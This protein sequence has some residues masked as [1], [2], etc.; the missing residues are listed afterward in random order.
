MILKP[1]IAT[2]AFGLATT[3][4]VNAATVDVSTS[5]VPTPGLTGFDTWTV[6]L[7]ASEGVLIG[8]DATFTGEQINQINPFTL[9]TVFSDSNAAITGSGADPAQDTQFLFNTGDLTIAP[10][11]SEESGELL[12]SA[13]ALTGGPDSSLAA[14]SID[15]AQIVLPTG[16]SAQFVGE[17]VVFDTDA[18]EQLPAV[19]VTATIPEPTSL[20]LLSLGGFTL[21][22]RRRARG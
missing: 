14:S 9:A 22:A 3:V 10:G 5:S 1:L 11:T 6:T 4:S 2:A 7:T 19:D 16:G 12:T 8:F 20:A 13:F 21:M 17:I 15:L 18:G